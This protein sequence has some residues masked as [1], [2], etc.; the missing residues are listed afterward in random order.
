[1][2]IQVRRRTVET[3]MN[4]VSSPAGT[5]APQDLL[6]A[7]ATPVYPALHCLSR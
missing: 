7:P 2:P 6:H 3:S 1:M 4:P 5:S